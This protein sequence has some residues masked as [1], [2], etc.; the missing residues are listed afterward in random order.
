M[1]TSLLNIMY[2]DVFDGNYSV[3]NTYDNTSE[4]WTTNE[5]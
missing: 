1:D 3:Y 5:E 2:D 4:F